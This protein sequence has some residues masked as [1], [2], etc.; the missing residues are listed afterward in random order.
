MVDLLAIFEHLALHILEGILFGPGII[1]SSVLANCVLSLCNNYSQI[2]SV[3]IFL[4]AYSIWG[5]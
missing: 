2:S 4:Y 3:W 5:Q 1:H